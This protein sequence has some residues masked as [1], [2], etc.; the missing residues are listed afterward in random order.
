MKKTMGLVSTLMLSVVMFTGCQ[1]MT[2]S[3]QRIGAAAL[4]GA[5]LGGEAGAAVGGA[6]GGSAGAAYGEKK[7]KY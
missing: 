7:G 2:P 6:L 4:G 3:N 1:N 5:V